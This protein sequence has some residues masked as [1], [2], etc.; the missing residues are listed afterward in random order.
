MLDHL[1]QGWNVD[2]GEDLRAFSEACLS[3]RQSLLLE[4]STGQHDAGPEH[5]EAVAPAEPVAVRNEPVQRF[6]V[7]VRQPAVVEV[8]EHRAGPVPHGGDQRLVG[9]LHPRRQGALPSHV[10][11]LGGLP[12][13]MLIDPVERLLGLPRRSQRGKLGG[14]GFEDHPLPGFQVCC[15]WP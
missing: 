2:A 6:G 4:C 12:A 13:L 11:G 9:P 14:P 8:V 1:A 7:G 3:G 15:E 10:G 5:V